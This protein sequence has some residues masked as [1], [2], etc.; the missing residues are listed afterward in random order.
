MSVIFMG[1]ITFIASIK[2]VLIMGYCMKN[3]LGP[4]SD[5]KV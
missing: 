4:S 2:L 1:T 3:A 5:L